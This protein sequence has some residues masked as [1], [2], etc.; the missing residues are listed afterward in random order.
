MKAWIGRNED[1]T[2]YLNFFKP[3]KQD[4][5][6]LIKAQDYFLQLDESYFDL[7]FS[8]VKW[9]DDE[10]TEIELHIVDQA[11]NNYING[12]LTKDKNNTVHFHTFKPNKFK[13]R[14]GNEIDWNILEISQSECPDIDFRQL[15]W[16]D[17]KPLYVHLE[18]SY[19]K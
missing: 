13:N 3:Y 14:W 11:S 7:D 5:E 1:G 16:N 10:P 9:E 15:N 6:W 18:L 12:Y 17:D 19:K 2:L 8:N 4:G